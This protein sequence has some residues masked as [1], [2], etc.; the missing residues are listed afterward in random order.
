MQLNNIPI[1]HYIYIYIY[2]YILYLYDDVYCCIYV[3]NV[4]Q[5]NNKLLYINHRTN[6]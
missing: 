1:E 2:I 3:L 6:S 5:L 4:G